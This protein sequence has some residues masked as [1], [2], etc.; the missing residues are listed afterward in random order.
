MALGLYFLLSLELN[1]CEPLNAYSSSIIYNLHSQY[2]IP[3]TYLLR[4]GAKLLEPIL[5]YK[6]KYFA[7]YAIIIFSIYVLYL[8]RSALYIQKV[9]RRQ[10]YLKKTTYEVRKIHISFGL[11]HLWIKKYLGVKFWGWGINTYIFLV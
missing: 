2:S 7:T 5:L 4:T 8:I 9:H 11:Y 1:Y 10:P 6:V 3:I